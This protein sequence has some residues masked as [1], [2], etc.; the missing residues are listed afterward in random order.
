MLCCFLGPIVDNEASQNA[1]IRSSVKA[2]KLVHFRCG[3][4]TLELLVDALL[5]HY[6][7]LEESINTAKTVATVINNCKVLLKNFREVQA[8]SNPKNPCLSL[9]VPLETQAN[10]TPVTCFW[11]GCRKLNAILNL[12]A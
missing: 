1:G 5:N 6:I 7:G 3:A 2:S 9:L 4:H 11:R 8:I 10:G 12:C